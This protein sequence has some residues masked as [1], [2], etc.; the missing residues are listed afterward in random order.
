MYPSKIREKIE[1]QDLLLSSS[2]FSR[3]WHNAAAVYQ[4]GPDWVWID[5]EHS[6][7]GTESLGPICVMAR[8]AGVAGV[9]RV[10]WNTPADIKKAYDSGAVG[11]MVPQVDNANEA[12]EAIRYS[13]YPPI[14]ERGIAPWFAGPMGIPAGDVITHANSETFLILQMESTEAYESLDETLALNDFEVLL[15][16]PD[17]LA[18]SLGVPGNKYHEKVERVMRDV[19]ERMRGTGKSLATTF[20]TPEEARRWIAEGYRMMNIGSVVSIGTIQMKEVYA[21]LREEFA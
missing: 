21:E 1:N 16:G 7:W 19:A 17:D 18:A 8:Q 4:T 2:I 9:I 15:V 5:Q 20:G 12:K 6:P 13:K 3:E 11:V 14:G 10:P